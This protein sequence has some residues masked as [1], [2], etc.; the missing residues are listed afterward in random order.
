[1][2]NTG[3]MGIATS[4]LLAYQQAL[5]TTSN[6][7][8]NT[9]TPGYARERVDLSTVSGQA[10]GSYFLGSGVR[11]DGVQRIVNQF[12]N[13]QLNAATSANA[14]Y[15]AFSSYARQVDNLLGNSNTGLQPALQGFFNAVQGV[16]NTPASIPARQELISQGNTLTGRFNTLDQQINDINTRLNG[17]ISSTVGEINSLATQIAH[18]NV[19]IR[20]RQTG[21]VAG[22]PNGLLDQRDQLIAKL[23]KLVSVTTVSQSDGSINV[24]VGTGQA[25]VLGANTTKLGTTLL[26]GDPNQLGLVFKTANGNVPVTRIVAGGM[27]GGLLDARNKII[28]PALNGLGRLAVGIT[29]AFNQ[30][31][32]KGVDLNG[33]PGK[34]FFQTLHPSVFPASTNVSTSG[35]P[36]VTFA[37]GGS[38]QLSVDNYQLSYNGT[39]WALTDTTTGQSVSMSGSG[40]GTSP[41][42]AAGLSIVVPTNVSAGDRYT[43]EPT[44]HG[45]Q[46]IAMQITSPRQIAAAGPMGS[47]INAANQGTATISVP[48]LATNVAGVT[49]QPVTITI[50]GTP[51]NNTWTAINSNTKA[52]LSTGTYNPAPTG[53]APGATIALN[54]WQVTL[55]GGA[56]S[57]DRFTVTPSGSGDNTNALQLAKVQL[58]QFMEK[59]TASLGVVYRQLVT[60]IGSRTQSAQNNADAQQS[61]LQQASSLQQSISG[62][63][64][65][66]EAANLLKY[67]QAYQAS[68]KVIATANTLFQTLL[69]AVR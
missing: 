17:Q 12:A 10:L 42:Q 8:A 45:A 4:S 26:N 14:R 41:Y 61:L 68:A 48:T 31:Q 27:L 58:N 2:A 1:M 24:M 66:Q 50:S 16:A 32:I 5:Q 3:I 11:V 7:I 15:Q 65:D 19:Q 52:T 36:T 51:P 37:S 38:S 55:S 25:L 29:A 13:T 46:Q 53:A 67:Q 35:S 30:Q 40:T 64:L 20:S 63:N 33:K 43:I 23:S 69:N 60:D 62:V 9:N 54:G 6:N 21:N 28:V 44:R 22:K 47:A 39:Q 34:N 56:K 59:G 18:V 49:L 57:G